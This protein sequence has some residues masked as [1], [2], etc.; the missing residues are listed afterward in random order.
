[1]N[2]SGRESRQIFCVNE[3]EKSVGAFEKGKGMGEILL[4]CFM[5]GWQILIAFIGYKKL[6][7]EYEDIV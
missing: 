2:R 7:R 6:K 4:V 1:M 3:E 5:A